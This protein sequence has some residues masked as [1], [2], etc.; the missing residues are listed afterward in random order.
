MDDEEESDNDDEFDK[1]NAIIDESE[2]NEQD[3][4]N[5]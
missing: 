2:L 4:P 5:K 1:A 3:E